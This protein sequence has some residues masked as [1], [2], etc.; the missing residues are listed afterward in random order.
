MHLCDNELEHPL[1]SAAGTVATGCGRG[2]SAAGPRAARL[3]GG[4]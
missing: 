4:A 2:P 1:R 3:R